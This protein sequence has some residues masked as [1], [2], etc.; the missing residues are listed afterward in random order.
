MR[1]QGTSIF[2]RVP[3]VPFCAW[4]ARMINLTLRNERTPRCGR[5]MGVGSTD[6][7]HLGRANAP[8]LAFGVYMRVWHLSFNLRGNDVLTGRVVRA[9]RQGLSPSRRENRRSLRARDASQACAGVDA[10][11][12][13]SMQAIEAVCCLWTQGSTGIEPGT[14]SHL[15]AFAATVAS[16][17]AG[18][19]LFDTRGRSMRGRMQRQRANACAI[20]KFKIYT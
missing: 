20:C 11:R 13:C 19:N 4:I 9:P 6:E 1:Q 7:G 5:P 8:W 16:P 14:L 12:A 17:T 3:T 18:F 15:Q 10:G 2:D